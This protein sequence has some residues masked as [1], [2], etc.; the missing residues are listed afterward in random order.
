VVIP[1]HLPY[2]ETRLRSDADG[3]T[4]KDTLSLNGR[5]ADY[6]QKLSERL[7]QQTAEQILK[8]TKEVFAWLLTL[9]P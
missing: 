3:R 1:S 4:E 7:D 6:R 5:Y 8:Q 2:N 9:R